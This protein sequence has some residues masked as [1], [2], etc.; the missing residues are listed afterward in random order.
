[1]MAFASRLFAA[2]L[3]FASSTA[4]ATDFS[5]SGIALGMTPAEVTSKA[6]EL[7]DKPELEFRNWK[8]EGG[9]SWVANG[10]L[11]YVDRSI[12]DKT[13]R[14]DMKFAFTGIGSGNKLFAFNREYLFN[15]DKQP[16]PE[17]VYDVLQ[18]K[19]GPPSKLS[20]SNRSIW[21]TWAFKDRENPAVPKEPYGNCEKMP[22]SLS[23]SDLET[24]KI[25]GLSVFLSIQGN[26]SGLA[27]GYRLTITDYL[28]APANVAADQ[29][30]AKEL[31]DQARSAARSS[32]AEPPKL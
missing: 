30:R 24:A 8:L 18:K 4:H 2:G 28:D 23:S 14:D 27:D 10:D 17:S 3:V 20:N 11:F 9:A 12:P 6:N 31:V 16:T 26:S 7:H 13:E 19:F 22:V 21:A 5:V 15:R 1:M 32:A 29:K 25:C